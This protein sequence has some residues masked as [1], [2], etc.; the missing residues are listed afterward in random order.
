MQVY[1]RARAWGSFLVV[2]VLP[3]SSLPSCPVNLSWLCRATP[4]P[5]KGSGNSRQSQCCR[6]F[7]PLPLIPHRYICEHTKSTHSPVK[8]AHAITGR[9]TQTRSTA[10]HP[11]MGQIQHCNFCKPRQLHQGFVRW[12][13]KDIFNQK[14]HCKQV[15]VICNR[16]GQKVPQLRYR[17]LVFFLQSTPVLF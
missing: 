6:S 16:T 1:R 2:D 5:H 3:F 9:E 8:T 15:E 11:L 13:S 14:K 4:D 17:V 12:I 7:P 10:T